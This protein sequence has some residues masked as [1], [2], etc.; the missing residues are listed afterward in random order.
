MSYRIDQ[1]DDG[2]YHDLSAEIYHQR[3]MGVANKSGLDEIDRSPD[4]Y[5]TWI[6]G[7][8]NAVTPALL[9]GS[10]MHTCILEPHRFLQ[11]YIAE[12]DFGDKR[13]KENK[14]RSEEWKAKAVGKKTIST[15]DA[16][17]LDNMFAAVHD[18]EIVGNMI[19]NGVPE[20]TIKWVDE[21]T[22]LVCKVR[23]DY[24]VEELEMVVDLKSTQDAREWAFAKSVADY[25]YHVQEALYRRGFDAVGHPIKHF[26][27]V[28]IEK[29]PPYGIATYHLDNEA[30][31][32]GQEDMLANMKKLA[33]CIEKGVFPSYPPN[34]RT[35][36]LPSYALNRRK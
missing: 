15:D 11:E 24:Y 10:A 33:E 19:R 36:S 28:A 12:P 16:R 9:F 17:H 18:H 29:V 35:L 22:G 2:I 34:I 1:L 4:H 7:R 23:P 14:A 26:L 6:D 27:F 3:V 5:K 32:A 13:F 30:L 20:A 25:R 8:N 31:A 21:E